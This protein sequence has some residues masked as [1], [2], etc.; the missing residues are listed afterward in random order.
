MRPSG[1]TS[2]QEPPFF[3]SASG[4]MPSQYC[5]AKSELVSADQSRSGVV[6]M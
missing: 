2:F 4:V 1:W 6:L 3:H 5:L